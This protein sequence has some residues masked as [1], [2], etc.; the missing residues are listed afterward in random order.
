MAVGR[1]AEQLIRRQGWEMTAS[2]SDISVAPTIAELRPMARIAMDAFTEGK[3]SEVRLAFTDFI[4]SL[5][6]QPRV[7][8]LLPLQRIDGV[9]TGNAQVAKLKSQMITE[10]LFEPDPHAVLAQMLP[11]LVELQVYQAYLETGASEH[12]ARMFAMRSATDAAGEMIDDLTLTFNSARQSLITR[13]IAE[14]SAGTAAL[15]A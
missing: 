13:E 9:G 7:K 3:V 6:Q 10:F 2:F 1:K 8:T 5:R 12:S 4:S 15:A 14:I 11:R